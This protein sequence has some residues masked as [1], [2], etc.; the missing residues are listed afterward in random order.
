MPRASVARYVLGRLVWQVVQNDKQ[1]VITTNGKPTV[2][3]FQ[4][5]EQAGAQLDKLVAGKLADGY[6]AAQMDPREPALE[7][8]IVAD[9]DNDAAYAVYGDWLEHQGD[10]RGALIALQLA[11]KAGDAKLDAAAKKHLAEHADYFIGSLA[12]LGDG[13]ISWSRGFVDK[14]YLHEASTAM[15]HTLAGA[16]AHPSLRFV[17]HIAVTGEAGGDEAASVLAA[18]VPPTLRGLRLRFR[19]TH[20]LAALW[21]VMPNLRRLTLFGEKLA[22]GDLDLPV[23][24]RL[25]ISDQELSYASMHAIAHAPWP[26]LERLRIDFGNGY[27]TGDASIDDVF[28]LLARSDLPALRRLALMHTRYIREVVIEL[29]TSPLALQLEHLDLSF[30][31]MTDAHALDLV[32]HKDRFPKLQLLDVSSNGLSTIGLEA[33]AALAPTIRTLHQRG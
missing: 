6:E 21:P 15:A 20:D 22:L 1:L 31:H 11:A 10:P 28:A 12:A 18:H 26:V 3:T 29:G 32:R 7:A 9:P 19:R 2:R 30:N 25:D 4:T 16:L 17:A 33:L 24:E 14:L 27:R 8:A 5:A 23:L 13:A